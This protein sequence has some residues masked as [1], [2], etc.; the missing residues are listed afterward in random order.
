MNTK[1][2]VL[3]EY[4]HLISLRRYFHQ[5]PEPALE[6]VK[7]CEKIVQE[8]TNYKIP[9]EYIAKTAIVATINGT[10]KPTGKTVALR[11]DIDALKMADLKNVGY[12]S[13]HEG[14]CHACGHD[15]HTATLLIAAKILKQKSD[16]FSGVIKLFFQPAEEVGDGAHL[17]VNQGHLKGVE[18]VFSV[19][20][21]SS[22][23]S[24]KIAITPGPVQASCDLFTIEV[25]GRGAHVAQPQKG[26]D[27]L[28]IASQIVINLQSIASRNTAALD[29]VIVGIGTM[30]A[31]T[32]YNIVA[33][34]A[35]LEG[36]TR[37]FTPEIR[38]FT[39]KR[40][41]E[42][43][44]QTAELFGGSAKISWRDLAPPVINEFNA[45]KE[46]QKIA[47]LIYSPENVITN[48][49]KQLGA[50]DFALMINETK[51]VYAYVG[52]QNDEN[53]NTSVAHHHG[54]F[55]IDEKALINS[56][57]MYID[58]ALSVLNQ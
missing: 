15:A 41:T 8:L 4:D 30:Q 23:P 1:E 32:Q 16:E 42:I 51:G 10:K 17:F 53:S 33:E 21:S 14:L 20:V 26:I 19:H 29:S 34:G 6:E 7:T 5:H 38:N 58:Y 36:T 49:E 55:D 44:K 9:F 47:N 46:A 40:V 56:V 27:A 37:A 25:T 24:G 12:K 3:K 54:L 52:T 48:Q 45:T 35:K 13:T 22:I 39:N 31:G 2:L 28:Y 57:R 18:R 50:D 11:S 43:A